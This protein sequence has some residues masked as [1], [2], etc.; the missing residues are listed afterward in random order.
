MPQEKP[1]GF[2]TNKDGKVVPRMATKGKKAKTPDVR[3][4]VSDIA[5]TSCTK[6]GCVMRSGGWDSSHCSL[7]GGR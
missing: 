4:T 6:C 2:F 3:N 1:L 5:E 7:H